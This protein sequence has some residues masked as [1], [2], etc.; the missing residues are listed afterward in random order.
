MSGRRGVALVLSCAVLALGVWTAAPAAKGKPPVVHKGPRYGHLKAPAHAVRRATKATLPFTDGFEATWPGEW[1]E[2]YGN[3]G[4]TTAQ[5]STGTYSA[6]CVQDVAPDTGPYPN[7]SNEWLILGPFST[8][9]LVSGQAVFSLWQQIEDGWDYLFAGFSTDGNS[10]AGTFYDTDKAGWEQQTV[11]MTDP[12]IG[13]YIGKS[14]V[15]FALVF[16]SDSSYQDVGS[17][18]DDVTISG[19]QGGV[20]RG[21]LMGPAGRPLHGACLT[22]TQGLAYAATEL[23][24]KQDGNYRK[25]LA[26]GTYTVA[27]H[28]PGYTFTPASK[29]VTITTGSDTVASFRATYRTGD[30]VVKR[31]ALVVGISEYDDPSSNLQYSDDDA[32]DVQNWLAACGWSPANIQVLLNSQATKAA[33]KAGITWLVTTADADDIVLFYQSG[34]GTTEQDLPPYDEAYDGIDESLC[35]YE[36]LAGKFIRDDELSLWFRALRTRKY[37]VLLDTCFSGGHIR[38]VGGQGG[39]HQFFDFLPEGPQ[40]VQTRDLDDLNG[41]VVVTACRDYEYSLEMDELQNGLF[42]YHLVD[43]LSSSYADMNQNGFVSAEELYSYVRPRVDPYQTVDMWDGYPNELEFADLVP[44]MASTVP[45]RGATGV[46]QTADLTI[47]WTWTVNQASAESLFKL[48]D[49]AGNAVPG[50]FTWPT[51]NLVMNFNPTPTLR[52]DSVYTVEVAPGLVLDTGGIKWY[53]DKFTFR[54]GGTAAIIRPLVVTAVAQQVSG[55]AEIRVNLSTAAN[56]E[57]VVTN[58]AGRVIRHLAPVDA[59]AGVST[60]LWNGKSNSGLSTPAGQYL[61]RIQARDAS[62][63]SARFVTPLRK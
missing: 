47:T 29:S 31:Y 19:V 13:D 43:G 60:L 32:V 58:I 59:E 63:N 51:P 16:Q 61:V 11:S 45:A 10:F 42:T 1:D 9:D 30:G 17:Y 26:P 54:T 24:T 37:V 38:S 36:L 8:A 6:Y 52:A 21:R 18:V 33:I 46:S 62:G 27:P 48:K 12:N 2:S 34:H 25:T 35:T 22:F 50:V 14:Q 55:G 56:V 23:Y 20:V 7:D 3:W 41:G 53:G 44:L 49:P 28:M 39:S 4:R 57:A 5:V 40:G 15:Y